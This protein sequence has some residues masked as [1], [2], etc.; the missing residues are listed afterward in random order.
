MPSEWEEYKF[1]R[2]K[3]ESPSHR[4][5][6]FWLGYI[7]TLIVSVIVLGLIYTLVD[8]LTVE[9]LMYLLGSLLVILILVFAPR[10][11]IDIC[12]GLKFNKNTGDLEKIEYLQKQIDDLKNK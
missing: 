5:L 3:D 6:S 12:R 2:F 4:T 8:S 11:I 9:Q 10:F 7:F 1:R